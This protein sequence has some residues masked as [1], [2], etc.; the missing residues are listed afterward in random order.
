MAI[1]EEQHAGVVVAGAREPAHADVAVVPVVGRVEPADAP[2]GVGQRSVPVP[3]ISSA[4]ITVIDAG[5]SLI[6]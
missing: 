6:S 1:D 4:V 5:A 2:E 3:A